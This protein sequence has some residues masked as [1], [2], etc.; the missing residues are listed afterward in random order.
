MRVSMIQLAVEASQSPDERR[1]RA[2]GAVR[3][4]EVLRIRSA[5]PVLR[6]RVLGVAPAAGR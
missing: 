5:L 6:D 4:A 2:A 3:M 1:R